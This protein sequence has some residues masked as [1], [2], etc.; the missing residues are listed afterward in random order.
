MP[1]NFKEIAETNLEL[2]KKCDESLKKDYPIFY[3]FRNLKAK[4]KG[5]NN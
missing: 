3:F 1:I 4:I 2:F 5:K